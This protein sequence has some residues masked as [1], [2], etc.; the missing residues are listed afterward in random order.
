MAKDM[1]NQNLPIKYT[2]KFNNIEA[3]QVIYNV[4]NKTGTGPN[5][6]Y[7]DV[8]VNAG[9][10][11]YAIRDGVDALGNPQY[12]LGTISPAADGK[13]YDFTPYTGGGAAATYVYEETDRFDKS[14]ALFTTN[15]G[16]TTEGITAANMS[17]SNSWLQGHTKIVNS[18]KFVASNDDNSGDNSNTLKF[19]K[20]FKKN[21]KFMTSSDINIFTGGYENFLS[22]IGDT[23]ALDVK[24]ESTTHNSY[25]VVLQSIDNDRMSV[26]GVSIDEEAVDIYRFQRAYEASSRVMTTMDEML[27]KLINSTGVVGR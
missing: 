15:D 14:H 4:V 12:K 16:V 26:S 23:S 7:D 5:T 11:L 1:N 24:T 10:Q 17:L 9:D 25:N 27:D 8:T 19:I 22:A 18:N 6:H 2:S 13:S 21:T 20:L 3:G